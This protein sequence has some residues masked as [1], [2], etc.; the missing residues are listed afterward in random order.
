MDG[1][2]KYFDGL[3][4]KIKKRGHKKK[5]RKKMD[6]AVIWSRLAVIPP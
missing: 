4:Y 5:N 1:R 2:A 3:Y 6:I